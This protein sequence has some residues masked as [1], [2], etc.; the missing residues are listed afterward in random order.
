MNIK[1]SKIQPEGSIS[2]QQ[3]TIGRQHK[4]TARYKQEDSMNRQMKAG[5]GR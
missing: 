5:T 2:G 3:D 1:D 4:R